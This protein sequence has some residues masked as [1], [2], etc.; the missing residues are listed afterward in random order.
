MMSKR[1]NHEWMASGGNY[2]ML[3]A[4]M[5]VDFGIEEALQVYDALWQQRI[6]SGEL[7]REQV[8]MEAQRLWNVSRELQ[9]RL[10][11]VKD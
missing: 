2:T 8:R 6:D 7:A 4:I 9:F 5:N 3:A 10:R 11:A 1:Q